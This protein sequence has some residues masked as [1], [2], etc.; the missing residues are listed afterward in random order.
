M[1]VFPA[2]MCMHCVYVWYLWRPEEG[3]RSLELELQCGSGNQILDPL[4][5][6]PVLSVTESSFQLICVCVHMCV[7][8]CTCVFVIFYVLCGRTCLIFVITMRTVIPLSR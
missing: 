6:Q 2:C 3:A 1:G 4:E 5:E 7:Y 8:V